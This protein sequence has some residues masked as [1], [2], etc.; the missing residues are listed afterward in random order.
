MRIKQC[1]SSLIPLGVV[2]MTISGA[3]GVE[4]S[5]HD[6]LRDRLQKTLRAGNFKD[7]YE[8]FRDL[9]LNPACD[10]KKVGNDLR[11]G[12]QALERLNRVA[13]I[14]AFREAVIAAHQQNW[15]LLWAAAQSY[16]EVQ[17]QGFIVAGKFERGQHRG[18]GQVANA[19]ERDR[20]RALQ[21]MVQA[22][23]L[24]L[25]DDDRTEAAKFLLSLA[26]VWL[27]Q[28]GSRESWRL[29]DLTD[30]AVLPDYE[31]GWGHHAQTR[32]AP[33]DADGNPVFHHLPKR[34]EQARSDGQR[35]RWCL[36]QAAELDPRLLRDSRVRFAEF[37]HGQFGVQ[38]MAE[39][40]WFFGRGAV[41]DSREDQSGTYA[42][43]TLGEDET[44]ARLAT[45]IKRFKLP[46][47]FNCIKLYQQLA[48]ADSGW[49]AQA[50]E[51]L[52]T[53]F[54]NRRQYRRAAEYWR[55]RIALAPNAEHAKRRLEQIEGNWGRFEPVM[56]QPA[57]KGATVEFRFRN[58]KSVE[59]VAHQLQAEK[60]LEDVKSYIKSR[61]RQ[62]D[63]EK[64]NI[65]DLG[66][67]IVQKNQARYRGPQVA[68]WS[69]DL[70]P[71]ENHFDKRVT[72]A[73][74]LQKPGAYLL[75]AKMRDGNTSQIVLWVAD[76]AIAKMPLDRKVL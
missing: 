41:D 34:F 1:L 19:M 5:L 45:G 27:D 10:P 68:A 52:A 63:W 4:P 72:V 40:G 26:D 59:F 64:L 44:I 62:L 13:E 60:L 74:P 46:D 70:E 61:P 42:L 66:W 14:D 3:G 9:A 6:G 18:G 65:A 58:G 7:A 48:E 54:E 32:G 28:R 69:M 16:V 24:A 12:I 22:L 33:V 25:R 21:L 20:V 71:R 56:T 37:L 53:V 30:L 23:P 36:A 75:T 15:R 39:Y 51:R 29:Q 57:G 50:L 76:S 17:H 73:S 43:H 47:E 38:T 49:Q 55:Q 8:G 35:W 11:M 67:R 2:L 31:P